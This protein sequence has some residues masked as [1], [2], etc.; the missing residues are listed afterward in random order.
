MD[1]RSTRD[2]GC[3]RHGSM[4][5]EEYSPHSPFRAKIEKRTK[6]LLAVTEI[7]FGTTTS[8]VIESILAANAKGKIKVRHVDDNTADRVEILIELPPGSDVDQVIQQ[9]YVFTDCQMSISPAACVIEEDKPVFLSIGY[10]TCYWWHA[11]Y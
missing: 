3:A 10:S 11:S 4:R 2:A 6:Y 7:P 8:S 9:L 5:P 1:A